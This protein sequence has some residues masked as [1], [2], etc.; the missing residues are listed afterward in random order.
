MMRAPAAPRQVRRILLTVFAVLVVA[1]LF[2][3]AFLQ[4][5]DGASVP[6][7]EVLFAREAIAAGSVIRAEQL[8]TLQVAA[9]EASLRATFLPVAVR[10]QVVGRVVG[11]TVPAGGALAPAHLAA[12][13]TQALGPDQQA[14]TIAVD[15]ATAV[16]GKIAPGDPVRV[17]VTHTEGDRRGQTRVVLPRARVYAV[18]RERGSA[19]SGGGVIGGGGATGSGG[20]A[21]TGPLTAVTLALSDEEAEALTAA[22]WDGHLDVALLPRP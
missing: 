10:A 14:L 4:A 9:D 18:S 8:G 22:K 6:R 11:V 21:P 12:P 2:A 1:A 17:Y 20:T 13:G 5:G 3:V 15:E 19:V 7:T 16:G